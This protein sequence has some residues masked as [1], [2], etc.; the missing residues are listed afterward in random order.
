MINLPRT[1][2]IVHALSHWI[3]YNFIGLDLSSVVVY[4]SVLYVECIDLK[5][6]LVT[7]DTR[8]HFAALYEIVCKVGGIVHVGLTKVRDCPTAPNADRKIL[9]SIGFILPVNDY[10]TSKSGQNM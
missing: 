3:R 8:N 9:L 2:L 10:A 6:L 4:C 7:Y 5:V 1:S